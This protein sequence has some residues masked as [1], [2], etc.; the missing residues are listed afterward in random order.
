MK[1][2]DADGN[3]LPKTKI[4]KNPNG[5][6]VANPG[7]RQRVNS[8][9]RKAD[10]PRSIKARETLEASVKEAKADADKAQKEA[11]DAAGLFNI[12]RKE[13]DL[14]KAEKAEKA[15][16]AAKRKYLQLDLKLE[17]ANKKVDDLKKMMKGESTKP[18]TGEAAKRGPENQSPGKEDE[19]DWML[20]NGKNAKKAAKNAKKKTKEKT[21][22]EQEI[23]KSLFSNE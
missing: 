5:V 18:T 6:Y 3:T 1:L 9:G 12:T 17:V 10:T 21:D 14:K 4:V 13:D 7:A 15:A 23:E 11:E 16:A 8:V 19:D 20:A 22:E 2:V